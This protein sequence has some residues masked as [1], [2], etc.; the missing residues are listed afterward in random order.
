MRTLHQKW[1]CDKSSAL[2]AA[3]LAGTDLGVADSAERKRLER[4]TRFIAAN[5]T[6]EHVGFL[7][8]ATLALLEKVPEAY[9]KDPDNELLPEAVSLSPA[10]AA[11]QPEIE[12]RIA[13]GQ[14]VPEILIAHAVYLLKQPHLSIRDFL[15]WLKRSKEPETRD[16]GVLLKALDDNKRCVELDDLLDLSRDATQQTRD[17]IHAIDCLYDMLLLLAGTRQNMLWWLRICLAL[18]TSLYCWPLMV[19]GSNDCGFHG[20]SLPIGMFLSPDGKSR[21]YFKI[22][23]PRSSIE[24][25][26]YVRGT[27]DAWA[28]MEGSQLQWNDEW[29]RAFQ[30]G[31]QVAKTLWSTQNGRLRFVDQAAADALIKASLVVDM[32][33]ACAIVDAVFDSSDGAPYRLSGRSA[34][35]YWVQAVLGMMLPGRE[36]PLGVVTGR[37]Q[38]ANG[39]EEIHH[40][41]GIDKKLE[42][43]NNAGFS[44]VVL[45]LEQSYGASEASESTND[46]NENDGE[47]TVSLDS[48]SAIAETQ[49]GMPRKTK[50]SPAP[51]THQEG[52][53]RHG[54]QLFLQSL[55]TSG[56]SKRIEINLCRSVRNVAD[57]MQMSGWRRTAFVRLPETQRAF[58]IHLR[59]LFL[60]EKVRQGA[61]LTSKDRQDYD[62]H[63]WTEKETRQLRK[64]DDYLLS[65]T[66]AI[67]FINRATF[68][69]LFANGAEAE[70][71][72]WL[73]WKDHQVRGGDDVSVRGPALGILCL[74]T[75]ET[76]N[77]MRLWSAIADTLSASPEWWN[78]FRW[79]SVDQAAQLLAQLLGNRRANPT[80]CST[81]AP[82]LLVLFDEGNLTQ[83]RTNPIF[84]DDFR[85]QWIDLLNPSKNN[86]NAAHPLNEALI[87]EGGGSLSTRIIVVYGQPST[88]STELPESLD[89]D[90][91][92]ALRRLAVFRF[93]CSKQAAYAMM[94][95]KRPS[96]ERLAWPDVD[97]RLK[98][99]IAR[100][101]LFST[102]GRFYVAPQ[103]L[104]KL[105]E[106]G[107]YY[108]DPH[109][110]LHAAKA[111]API[112][113]PRDL[114]IASNRDRT[115]EP[116]SVL[117][118]TWH[119]QRARVL[120]PARTRKVRT[121]CETALAT[122]TFL[123]PFP[124]WD[125]V[126]LLQRSTATL[127]DAV[128]LGRE[129]VAQERSITQQPPH[130]S[131][132]A[133]L[134]N[135][136][137][138]FG[139]SLYGNGTDARRAQL[140]DEATTLCADA[141]ATFEA[142]STSDWRRQ[143]RKLFSEYVY[144]MKLLNVPNADPR[145]AG[146]LRYLQ[147]TIDEV[148]SS[149]FYECRD[150]DDYPV[151]RDWL[152]A[153]WDDVELTPRDRS[154]AAYVAARLHIDRR[155]DGELV[156]PWDQPWI[157]YFALTTANDFDARQL[158][159]PLTTWQRVYGDDLESTARFGQRV[160]DFVSFL[161]KKHEEISWWGGRSGQPPITYGNSLTTRTP[162]SSY[163]STKRRSPCVS[164]E[165]SPCMRRSQRSTLS[166]DVGWHGFLNGR[167]V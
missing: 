6:T 83:R 1:L 69:E 126:K 98:A 24:H 81:P 85:G 147:G 35:A 63:P 95:Y 32:G 17:R 75:T 60:L 144:C 34:E 142:L 29:A 14:R 70:I 101:V 108:V 22:V 43:A 96:D 167:S 93:D 124:D 118:A 48:P 40:V 5:V 162:I 91:E 90:D 50:T 52:S 30:M 140:A 166:I 151:S 18:R 156:P 27:K 62:R 54:V 117:E 141:L 67:K 163:E 4:A 149:D 138:E 107:E 23:N 82:D 146:N 33:A 16:I 157:E 39:I 154:T 2:S 15:K 152:R 89:A 122:L 11:V 99:L 143:K 114:F 61:G 133:A 125:T 13:G 78:Q 103:L 77:E 137:G 123:R 53:V 139:R 116:E 68:D 150:L 9:R 145:L 71:G 55:A 109:A 111:L 7:A 148:V 105:R 65:D 134:F 120:V 79:S 115:L 47:L 135:A 3:I 119:L 94:N 86:P 19:A 113:E 106:V 97:E 155:R 44:R 88:R 37:V 84:P 73:A 72:R 25:R 92:D 153:R 49:D 164:S 31:L 121:Q 80:I 161:P 46:L 57:A 8:D 129:L 76:D 36:L 127:A 38:M 165:S 102:R 158:H 66:R 10:I 87:G 160:R 41:E 64:L 20:I 26:R 56:A 128:E 28:H 130:S 110:H 12:C 45:P 112:L 51:G 59:R 74:R 21:V 42:Y 136:L 104:P 159:R 100:R 131:R 58:A 132:V